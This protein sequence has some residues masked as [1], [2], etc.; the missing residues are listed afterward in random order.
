MYYFFWLLWVLKERDFDFFIYKIFVCV[1]I[2]N[3]NE[4]I[5]LSKVFIGG[6]N[7]EV[8]SMFVKGIYYLRECVNI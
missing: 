4:M 6:Y 8:V 3:I 7:W 1:N 5:D 2:I